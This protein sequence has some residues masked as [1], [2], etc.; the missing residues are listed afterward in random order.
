MRRRRSARACA[1]GPAARPGPAGAGGLGGGG[2]PDQHSTAPSPADWRAAARAPE[3]GAQARASRCSSRRHWVEPLGRM[4]F[5]DQLTLEQHLLSDVDRFARVWE[6]SVRGSATPLARGAAPGEAVELRRRDARP[7]REAAAAGALRLHRP[8]P[9]GPGRA[10]RGRALPSCDWRGRRFVCDPAPAL[11]LGRPAPGRGGPPPLPLHLRPPGGRPPDAD[12]LPGGAAGPRAWWATPAST[13][14]RTASA[15][16]KPVMLQGPVAAEPDRAPSATR[17]AG[18]GAASTST[19]RRMRGQ[20]HPVRFEI[21]ARQGAFA[22]TFC[23]AG[24]GA[25]TDGAC[26]SPRGATCCWRCCSSAGPAPRWVSAQRDQGVM[27][28]EATYFQ[29]AESYWG[30]FAEL[31]D[32]LGDRDNRQSASSTEQHHAATSGTTTS[33]R[34]SSRCSWPLSWRTAPRAAARA[35]GTPALGPLRHA[36]REPLT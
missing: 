17:T 25:A 30:W 2:H 13:T 27:R 14:S 19:P 15:V 7:V 12:H 4:H 26:Y 16:D 9:G 6:V 21:T 20:T 22:R 24:G 8:N 10:G 33:T 5:G 31:A 29:A 32:H 34:C 36:P 3:A 11:E 35:R 18:P 23:F 28:D 1:A